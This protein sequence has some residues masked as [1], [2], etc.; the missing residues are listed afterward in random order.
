[1][2][3]ILGVLK[4]GG[5]KVQGYVS[6]TDAGAIFVDQSGNWIVVP[7]PNYILF[8]KNPPATLLVH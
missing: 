5:I 3:E 6:G 4:E 7:S 1:M 8:M 2:G